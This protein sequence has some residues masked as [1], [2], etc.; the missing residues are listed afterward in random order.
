MAVIPTDFKAR[1]PEFDSISDARIQS[2]IDKALLNL[3]ESVWGDY[4]VE[5]QLYLAAHFLTLA[6]ASEN[7][8]GSGAGVAAGP[9]ASRSIGDVS[10][11]FAVPSD[12]SSGS[13]TAA[14]FSKTPYGLEY[15]RLVKI[16][17]EGLVAVV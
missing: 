16:V 15:W 2:F 4:F 10:V 13:G 12:V 6:I 14:Y 1:F 17:G 3:S 11:S 5:G 8:G 9:V 7:S